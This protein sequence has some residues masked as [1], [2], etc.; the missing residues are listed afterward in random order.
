MWMVGHFS[1]AVAYDSNVLSQTLMLT[2]RPSGCRLN[3]VS[4]QFFVYSLL[5][6]SWR[7]SYSHPQRSRNFFGKTSWRTR[8]LPIVCVSARGGCR[9]PQVEIPPIGLKTFER[10]L[11][12]RI[13][14]IAHTNAGLHA[15]CLSKML[16]DMPST[17]YWNWKSEEK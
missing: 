4:W 16:K 7:R 14:S 8:W 2:K 9:Q 11:F 15:V 6:T 3:A 5:G 1:R 13:V 17:S 10:K 12:P